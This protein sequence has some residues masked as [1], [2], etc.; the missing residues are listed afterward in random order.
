MPALNAVEP[1]MNKP[2]PPVFGADTRRFE[3]PDLDRHATWFMPRFIAAFPHLNERQAI[4]FLRSVL[5]SSEYLFLFQEK[6]IALA[7]TLGAHALEAQTVI[8]E[9]FVW[10]EDP[11]NEK[12]VEAAS[13]FYER[14]AD[15]A[16]RKTVSNIVVEQNTDVPLELIRARLKRI[17]TVEQKV[18][19]V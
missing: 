13:Y 16:K 5:Y 4:G 15:W 1:F 3:L 8:W 18:A 6:G 9:R 19:R 14:F 7:Q 12:Q 10:V 17:T 2:V 11:Q